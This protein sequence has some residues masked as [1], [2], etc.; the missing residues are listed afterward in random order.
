MLE[1]RLTRR[2]LLRNT[3]FVS[4]GALLA[5]CQPKPAAPTAPVQEV[6]KETAPVEKA[7]A[8]VAEPVELRFISWTS[9][10]TERDVQPYYENVFKEEH[11]NIKLTFELVPGAEYARIVPTNIVA[12]TLADTIHINANQHMRYY[13]SG[14]Y[15]EI[16]DYVD[17][18]GIDIRNDFWLTGAEIWCGRV[19]SIPSWGDLY[20]LYY[21]KS[22]LEKEWGKDIWRDFDNK[23][24]F[25]DF[26]EACI[27]CTK[28]T[29]GDGRVDQFGVHMGQ[30]SISLNA[31]WCWTMGGD[32]FDWPN[33]RTQV[34]SPISVEAHKLIERWVKESDIAV[35]PDALTEATQL[36][37][38]AIFA[39]GKVGF[40]MRSITDI[41]TLNEFVVGDNAFEW[42]IAS[43]PWYDDQHPGI[44]LVSGHPYCIYSKTKHPDE[45]FE[46]ISKL[47][48]DGM[49]FMAEGPKTY[50][51]HWYPALDAWLQQSPAPEHMN[52]IPDGF[53]QGYGIHFRMWT[54]EEVDRIYRDRMERVFFEDVPVVEALNGLDAEM[55]EAVQYGDCNPYTGLQIPMHGLGMQDI[56]DRR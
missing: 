40:W 10:H 37:L 2:D 34:E 41:S 46:W 32:F 48:T 44:Q 16:T 12:G 9:R 35:P 20:L 26:E 21:N 27:A 11:P 47:G 42:D 30:T 36:G 3:A 33:M 54:K 49:M 38:P 14:D 17:V 56:I 39:G 28:D 8:K 7:P 45:A 55:N 6:A 22:L 51:P 18:A 24:T 13:D 4:A 23:Y 29:N 1:K 31:Q 43:M 50:P 15:M 52:Y 25:A 5:A 19:M 53:A